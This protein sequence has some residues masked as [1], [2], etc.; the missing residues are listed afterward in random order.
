MD[1][2]TKLEFDIILD[3]IASSAPSEIVAAEIKRLLPATD[4]GL[5]NKLLTQTGDALAVLASH[6]PDLYF[7]DISEPVKK[8]GIGSV[9]SPAEFL[10]I[11][12]SVAALRSLKSSVESMSDCDSLK[13]IT[14]WVRPCEELER[15]IDKTI[16]NESEI[17]D[18]ASDKLF[19]LR[20]AIQRANAKLKE[21]LDGYTRQ[22]DISKYLRDNI[23]TVRGG[24]YVLPVRSDC[25]ANVKGLV[26]DVSATGATVFVEPFAVVESNNEIITL[27]TEEQTEIERILLELG[28]KVAANADQLMR[29]Q[30]VLVECGVIFAKA[31]YAKAINAYRPNVNVDGKINLIGA[32]HPL[33]DAHS[34]V[35]VDISPGNKKVLLI[36]GPNTGGKTVALKTVG[37]FSLLAA[38]G[39]FIPANEGSSIA[40]FE[41]VY[42]DIG[43]SQSITQSLSTFSAH[44]KNLA[45]ITAKMD[46]RSLVLLDE[47]GDGTDPEEGA[48]LAI[49]IIKKILASGATAVVTTHFDSVK[50]FALGNSDIANACMQF[51]SKELRPTYRLLNGVSGSSYAL[52]IAERLGLD[53]EI[54]FDARNALSAEKVALDTVMREAE[55]LRNDIVYE[56]QQTEVLMRETEQN[57]VKAREIKLEYEKKLSEINENARAIIRRRADDYSEK[58]ESIIEEIKSELKTADEAALFRA[59]KAAKK[60][61]E[62]VPSETVE[63]SISSEPA[64]PEQLTLG[65]QVYITGFNKNGI[66][67]SGVRGNKVLVAIGSIKTELPV[68]SL[69]LVTERKKSEGMHA[70]R[71]VG[72]PVNKEIMLLGY[73]V[74]D[75]TTEIDRVISDIPPHSTLRI[76]HG[77]GTGALGKGIQAYL[78]RNPKIKSFRYGRYGEGDTGVTIAELK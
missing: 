53:K 54:I 64:L 21:R 42:C 37:L 23:V 35:P 44:I 40:I 20:R 41:N 16:E 48:A 46:S 61:T 71:A 31:E 29:G 55:Q 33:I 7:E 45:E 66:I 19:S 18:G 51:D 67:A 32:R 22:S 14:A 2:N 69:S 28:R 25:R 58:A 36:S 15:E 68:S 26:H 73:T 75:A 3:K 49:A 38:C 34:V 50:R 39:I 24:R 76:V 11:K 63:T 9:L 43:D 72:E 62:N 52:E 1:C 59:R 5:V 57:S 60:L 47:V 17:K 4:A 65:T 13:D 30:E 77:K 12:L 56:K 6:K 78:K 10:R 70:T 27:K 8:A 74:D